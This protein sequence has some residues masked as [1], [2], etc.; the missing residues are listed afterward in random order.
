M[1][2]ATVQIIFLMTL[3]SV[4]NCWMMSTSPNPIVIDSTFGLVF[5]IVTFVIA[6][7]CLLCGFK[8]FRLLVMFIGY[9]FVIYL[10]YFIK[11]YNPTLDP[12][13]EKIAVY[14]GFGIGFIISIIVYFFNS[15]N[16][17]IYSLMTGFVLGFHC[18]QFIEYNDQGMYLMMIAII[19]GVVILF[20]CILSYIFYDHYI[21]V[22]SSLIGALLLSQNVGYLFKQMNLFIAF[23]NF[24]ILNILNSFSVLITFPVSLMVSIIIQYVYRIRMVKRAENQDLNIFTSRLTMD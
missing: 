23:E 2:L 9:I 3:L 7:F 12:L 6:A 15:M 14:G 11:S 24:D 1:K 5:L 17:I 4:S 21:I 20:G 13:F 16:F 19:I 8:F 10:I 22:S 18:Q